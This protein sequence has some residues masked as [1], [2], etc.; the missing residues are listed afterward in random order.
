MG[1]INEIQR[2]S[3]SKQ[4]GCG[5]RRMSRYNDMN[6]PIVYSRSHVLTNN[7]KRNNEQSRFI[8]KGTK[9]QV[10]LSKSNTITA[11]INGSIANC[12][13]DTGASIN[14]VD[15]EWLRNHCSVKARQLG[16]ARV[17]T[18]PRC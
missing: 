6:R 5:A 11:S 12:L 17:K 4:K 9:V 15:Y 14:L 10:K 1:Q 13:I 7:R 3:R 18:A 16:S 8:D 2:E